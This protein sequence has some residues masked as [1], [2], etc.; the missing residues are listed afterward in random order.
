MRWAQFVL[1]FLPISLSSNIPCGKSFLACEND[2]S[3]LKDSFISTVSQS[4][5]SRFQSPI[6]AKD[7]A[8]GQSTRIPDAL[9]EAAAVEAKRETLSLYNYSDVSLI[10]SAHRLW[11]SVEQY[12]RMHAVDDISFRQ[13]KPAHVAIAM[14]KKLTKLGMREKDLRFGVPSSVLANAIGEGC[15]LSSPLSCPPTEYR[16]FTGL[17]NNVNRPDSGASHT[18]LARFV[19]AEYADGISSIRHSSAGRALPSPRGLSVSLFSPSGTAHNEVTILFAHWWQFL[20]SDMI[21]VSPTQTVVSGESSPLPCCRRGFVHPEC[22]AV[23][24][25]AADPAYRGRVSCIPHSRS[26]VAARENCALGPREQANLASSFLDASAIYGSTMERARKMRQFEFGLLRTWGGHGD[27]P[28][29]D[30]NILCTSKDGRCVLS[31]STEANILPGVAAL[32]TIW[33][34]QHN[35]IAKKLRALNSHWTDDKLYEEARK[36]VSAQMQHVTYNEFLPILLGN[37]N[38]KR[39]GLNLHSSGFDADYDMNIDATVLNEFAVT[40]PYV[41]WALLPSHSLTK[42]FND[43]SKIYEPLG[44]E[45]VLKT[46]MTITIAKPS[47][48]MNDEVRSEFLK[49]KRDDGYGMDLVSIAIKQGRDHGIPGYTTVRAQC[50][51]GKIRYFA[52][53]GEVFH[54][55]V[56]S[57]YITTIYDA[58][59]DIDLLVGVLAERPLKGSLIGPTLACLISKQ[60]QRTRRGDRFWYENYFTPSSFNEKQLDE[61]RKTKLAEII[62]ANSDVRRIVPRVFMLENIFENN[63]ISCNATGLMSSPHF[64]AWKD[65]EI[66]QR[67]P[68][69]TETIAKVIRLAA[70]NLKDQAKREISNIKHNQKEFQKGDPLFAYSN[71]MRAKPHAKT[72]SQISAVLLETTKLLVKGEMLRE[73]EKLPPLDSATLATILPEIDVSSFVNNYTAFLS[74]DGQW[75]EE[76]CLPRMLPCD[77]TTR[78]RSYNGWCNNLRFPHYANSFGPLRHILPPQYDDGFDVPRWRAKS[79]RSLPNPRKVSNV[80]HEDKDISH[81]KFTHMVMQFGQ[82]L[83][84]EMTHSPVARGPNDEILNC[85]RCDS[86]DKISVHCMPIRVESDDPFFPTHYPDGEARCLP[87]A[88]S[89]LGQLNLGYRNQMNQLTSYIDGSVLYGST[90]CEAKELR[91]FTRGLL[92]FTD[93]GHGEFMLPQGPQEKDCRSLPHS[94]CFVAGDERNSHQPGLTVMHTMFMREHNRIAMQLSAMNPH[95]SDEV[96]YQETRRIVVAV[97]QQITFAEFLPKIVGSD[98]LEQ[99][100]LVPLK[101]G[102]FSGYDESCDAS[103]SQP[104]A[105]AAFR[106]GHT[107]IRRM[108]PRMTNAYKNMTEKVDLAMHFGH[109]GPLYDHKQGGMDTM[110][111]GLLGTPSMAFDRHITNAVR[112]HLFMRR[113]E[114]TSGMD[115]IAINMLRARDHGVQPYNDLREFCGLPRATKFDDLKNEIDEAGIKALQSVYEH[116][117]DIDLFPGLVSEAPRKGALLGTT[118]SCILAEQFGRLKRCDRFYYENDNAAAKFTPN[119]L[120]EIRKIRLAS[121]FCANSKY[122]KTIQPNVFDIPDDLMNAQVSCKD[123]P[124]IDLSHWKDRRHCEMNGRTIQMG[125]STHITPCITCTC[126]L[127]GVMCNP[128]RV[129]SCEKLSHKYLFSDISKDTSCMIQ[130][131]DMMKNRK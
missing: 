40:F 50:G 91:L 58:V 17:C 53:L 45:T 8:A 11:S 9:F 41:A 99:E 39:Y 101:N 98:L 51:L 102:Y 82:L 63:P 44:V 117:D 18:P 37:D 70:T 25:P 66:I 90:K 14:T 32:H 49:N 35:R 2:A 122:L 65:K 96:V 87:F 131:S 110:L 36:I 73:D 6:S 97:M 94:P 72:V 54:E 116:V 124:Q 31:G 29:A 108:F 7:S 81:V 83:D 76:E 43:P 68:V 52:D 22:D 120:N 125:E 10:H 69:K 119:Q 89:L 113:G 104:F 121:I 103:I 93:F 112:N 47:L 3:K 107:L 79:G 48:R 109:V 23:D 129:N 27:L 15:P 100:N 64:D 55:E 111:M 5:L 95:W 92:N 38:I 30:S 24:I 127:E 13:A 105:T 78:Y 74:A 62:C 115:L 46:L 106:F 42:A 75:T 60:F 77:H 16:S 118:M 28:D 114:P 33:I 126:T 123:V 71:M 86:P 19:K 56:K 84:H 34:K 12:G 1:I 20:S 21:G 85:T 128:T 130:C 59:E 88:R 80:V 67:F 4:Y 26:I 57:E 61:I